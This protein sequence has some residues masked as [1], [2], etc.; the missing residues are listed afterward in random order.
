[1]NKIII[2]N[3]QQQKLALETKHHYI[4][5]QNKWMYIQKNKNNVFLELLNGL[6]YYY[7]YPITMTNFGYK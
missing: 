2:W 7:S 1:M 5:L 3:K 6:G 4:Q